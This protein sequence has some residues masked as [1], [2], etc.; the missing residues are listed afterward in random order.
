MRFFRLFGLFIIHSRRQWWSP[1]NI[2][3][4]KIG[5]ELGWG[6]DKKSDKKGYTKESV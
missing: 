5:V 2:S 1:A 4:R 3:L 6:V